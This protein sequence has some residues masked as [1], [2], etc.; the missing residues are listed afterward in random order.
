MMNNKVIGNSV[1]V[2]FLQL[3]RSLE[4]KVDTGATT[5]SLHAENIQMD[6]KRGTVTF[7]CPQLSKNQITLDVDG[8]QEVHSADHG[9]EH[10]PMVR[11]DVEIEGVQLKATFNLND[12]SHMDTAILVGQNILQAGNFLINPNQD[13]ADAPTSES[14][15]NIDRDMQI[16]EAVQILAKHNVTIPELVTYLNTLKVHNDE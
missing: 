6:E 1:T 10:R 13:E 5:S 2:N 4:G 14:A 8:T 3:G 11:L 7:V 9:G 12:R 16:M 15:A